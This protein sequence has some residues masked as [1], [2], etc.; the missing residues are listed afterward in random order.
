MNNLNDE[1]NS[2]LSGSVAGQIK[3]EGGGSNVTIT[4]TLE[5]GTKIADFTVGETSGE[6]FAPT[7]ESPVEYTAGDNI[8]IEDGVIS[9]TDTT[10]TAGDGIS[11]ENGVI[12]ATGGGGGQTQLLTPVS[13]T[14]DWNYFIPFAN[15]YNQYIRSTSGYEG[16]C[17]LI[18]YDFEVGKTYKISFDYTNTLTNFNNDYPWRFDVSNDFTFDFNVGAGTSN[19]PKTAT[20]QHCE[21]QFTPNSNIAYL[22]FFQAGASASALNYFANF[23][24]EEI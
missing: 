14:N 21:Y 15:R 12:S 4:P 6:L 11:T 17:L 24:I 19:L 8:T 9:A 3:F 1:I 2:M 20:T 22:R 13:A 10:Y 18:N 16:S 23:T 7:P 5:T